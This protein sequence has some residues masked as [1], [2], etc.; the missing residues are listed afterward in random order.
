MAEVILD[1]ITKRYGDFYAVRDLNLKIKDGSF[2]VIV[3]PSGCGKSTTLR[4]VAGLETPTEGKIYIGGRDV[5]DLEPKDRNIAMVFQSY[6]LYPHMTVFDNMAFALKAGYYTEGGKR[7]RY[8]KEEIKRRVYEAAEI[9]GIKDQLNKKPSQ[10]SGGQRQRVAL[11]RALVRNPTVFL[12]DEPLSNLD[13]KLRTR[14]RVELKRLHKQ[15]KTTI[16]Y[17]THDQ[18]EAMTLADKIAVLNAGVLRQ[19]A[20]PLETYNRPA[21]RFVATFI[22]S[23]AMNIIDGSLIPHEKGY[24]FDAGDLKFD[25]SLGVAKAVYESHLATSEV[26]YG[27]R[28]EDV[29]IKLDAGDEDIFDLNNSPIEGTVFGLEALGSRN[30]AFVHVGSIEIVAEVPASLNLDIGKKCYIDLRSERGH[31]FDRNGRAIC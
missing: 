7:K 13:A 4:M 9:L 25:L 21:D 5:T 22:G 17:V 31:I 19:Y 3:G 12:M 27:I 14:M 20:S 6:A 11:G 24:T 8:S 28:P 15:L 2:V 10:L 30:Y 23:P 16:I 26:S 29:K 18:M 1:N